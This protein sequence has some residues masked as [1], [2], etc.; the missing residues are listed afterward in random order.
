MLKKLLASTMSIL[1]VL[2]VMM[3]LPVVATDT[4]PANIGTDYEPGEVTG[5]F[6]T[7]T[8][9][10]SSAA[11][12]N[13]YSNK[14][15]AYFVQLEGESAAMVSVEA[16][17]YQGYTGTAGS[18][19]YTA[20][21]TVP[22]PWVVYDKSGDYATISETEHQYLYPLNGTVIQNITYP[23]DVPN[24]GN[25]V[26]FVKVRNK[27]GNEG[28]KIVAARTRNNTGE[29]G[30]EHF[31]FS[32]EYPTTTDGMTVTATGTDSE[33]FACTF[34]DTAA[35]KVNQF[36][37]SLGM[38]EG[39]PAGSIVLALSDLYLGIEYAYDITVSADKEV[40]TGTSF[41]VD[42]DILN[43]GGLLGGI[44]QG[45]TW[46]AL[47]ADRTAAVEGFT[48]TEGENGTATVSVDSTVPVGTYNLVAVADADADLVKGV[49]IKVKSSP[50]DD[51][52]PGE[53]IG[54]AITTENLAGG[55]Y[56]GGWGGGTAT[57]VN[58]E[59]VWQITTSAQVPDTV[60]NSNGWGV[61]GRVVGDYNKADVYEAG[62]GVVV[63]Y[64]AKLD[65]GSPVMKIALWQSGNAPL[66]S[67]EKTGISDGVT[68][69]NT[70]W[71]TYSHTLLIPESGFVGANN[72]NL[73]IGLAY[74]GLTENRRGYYIKGGSVYV[75]KEYVYDIDV[76]A[77]D[78][79][80]YV[81][82]TTTVDADVLNQGG[83][84]GT[85]SQNVTWYALSDD[86][87]E[88]ISGITVTPGENGTATVTVAD[89][90]PS[91]TYDIVAVSDDYSGIQKGVSITVKLPYEDYIPGEVTGNVLTE[92]GFWASHNAGVTSYS[93]INEGTDVEA[94]S[95]TSSQ[96]VEET[97]ATG[98]SNPGAA[99][100]GINDNYGKS[101]F[102]TAGKSIVIG[103]KVVAG[104]GS[105][106]MNVG[107][108]QYGA[109]PVLPVEYPVGK[110]MT[111][112]TSGGW[113]NFGATI[114]IPETG[115]AGAGNSNL[116]VGF[117]YTGKTGEGHRTLAIKSGSMYIGEEYAYDINVW[118]EDT[119]L[120]K[121]ETITVNSEILNQVGSTG[122][123]SQNVTWYAVTADRKAKVD[124]FTFTEGAKGTAT[125]SV[126][127]TV[128]PGEYAIVAV[129]DNN[130]LLIKGT[131]IVVTEKEQIEGI[132]ITKTAGGI[133][134][135][136][137]ADLT[138]AQLIFVTYE[139]G[140]MATVNT[141]R[142]VTLDAQGTQEY[143]VPAGFE[144]AKVMLW[145]ADFVPLANILE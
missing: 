16:T 135:A 117:A 29:T 44:D 96:D 86:R 5:N 21:R 46:Y 71:Q 118:S 42:A 43:Q 73:S 65:Q 3:A 25:V 12:V 91:G 111:V 83:N 6:I 87:R 20:K 62:K 106:V 131:S 107:M 40:M 67:L 77:A 136:T 108:F 50:Y 115:F 8:S 39:T 98:A 109:A 10:A 119:E 75:G 126:A 2:T 32:M 121:G 102:L 82:G 41:T 80:I 58:G 51:Y 35:Q 18:V 61:L 100:L 69:T 124:G 143:P 57:T 48:I 78:T 15:G 84:T 22:N 19:M 114:K 53:I 88:E 38:P 112:S 132:T 34:E 137:D 24:D 110:G 13:S 93:K 55:N 49:T 56:V 52:V 59:S 85:L 28:A 74:T 7:N 129:S 138:D 97:I 17:N 99:G 101:T 133:T 72:V 105:P 37:Y 36:S 63:S 31:Q 79:T 9:P 139:G 90:V 134:V 23:D 47:N 11:Q 92:E 60:N 76:T 113:Q 26:F 95:F 70:D 141:E 120:V 89:T 103:A 81:G 140:K 54:N 127:D 144:N 27:N 45:V 125:V 94:W 128:E 68:V 142:K 66:Y 33:I 30:P 1:M 130:E 64:Q 116:Y 4:L 123:L 145:S 14:N 122:T 104:S